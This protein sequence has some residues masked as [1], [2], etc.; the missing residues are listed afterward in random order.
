MSE[1]WPQVVKIGKVGKHPNADTLSITQVLGNYPVIF[2][3]GEFIEGDVASYI[4]VDTVVPRGSSIHLEFL[5]EGTNKSEVRIK[6]KKLRGILSMGM[7]TPEIPEGAEVGDSCQQYFNLTKYEE[8]EVRSLFLSQ[9]V[10]KPA[11]NTPAPLYDLEGLRRYPDLFEEGEMVF[12]TEK[13][14]GANTR[15]TWVDGRLHVGSRRFWVDPDGD[16]VW[17]KAVRKH[18]GIETLCKEIEGA[19]LYG[20]TYGKVQ[21]LKYGVNGVA[22]VAYDLYDRTRYCS[23]MFTYA[24]CGDFDV[25]HVPLIG[26]M[27]FDIEEIYSLAEGKSLIPT[28][29]HVREGI[30]IA[31][32]IPRYDDTIGY[33]KL[34]LV[35]EGYLLK[36]KGQ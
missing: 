20:E 18:P 2:R 17:A 24:M 5:F 30:V 11:P 23:P 32:V 35:G 10:N 7:L 15:V 14:H 26:Q 9:G 22:F 29:D 34:K 28:A 25:P 16:S 3:T 13:I 1:W 27:S 31:P 6:A 33:A 8:P 12:V 21:E 36:K 4:P 19:V